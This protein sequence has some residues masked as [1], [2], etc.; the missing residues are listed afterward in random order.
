LRLELAQDVAEIRPGVLLVAL[1]PAAMDASTI[2]YHL[3][4]LYLAYSAATEHR[5]EVALEL[6]RGRELY[7]WFT[8]DG[9]REASSD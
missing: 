6:R 4:R 5:S 7:G 8:R 1:T 3:Q 2:M 9:L